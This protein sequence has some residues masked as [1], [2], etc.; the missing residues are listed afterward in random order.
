[1]QQHDVVQWHE[2]ISV[3]TSPT[4]RLHPLSLSL[5]HSA[6]SSQPQ[7]HSRS[8]SLLVF[9]RPLSHSA[10]S[11]SPLASHLAA[12]SL[13]GRRRPSERGRRI[14]RQTDRHR[15]TESER[16]TDPDRR[17]RGRA[18]NVSL[19][20]RL[21][22]SACFSISLPDC[23]SLSP[24]PS[25]PRPRHLASRQTGCSTVTF[26]TRSCSR[27]STVTLSYVVSLSFSHVP[28]HSASGG[29]MDVVTT[30]LTMHHTFPTAASFLQIRDLFFSSPSFYFSPSFTPLHAPQPT[31]GATR[32]VEPRR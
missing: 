32:R 4:A 2:S 3:F 20:L 11:L 15:Q 8:L 19:G 17:D 23:L 21:C 18:V 10:S 28:R 24:P 13:R 5:S 16:Q 12:R 14:R 29:T 7:P 25:Q 6:R 27:S 31:L 26:S 9:I 1:M 30:F 22:L